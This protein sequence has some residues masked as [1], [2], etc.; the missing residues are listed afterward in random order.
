MRAC[1]IGCSGAGKTTFGKRLAARLACPFVELDAIYHQAYW[2]P[3]DDDAF[4]APADYEARTTDAGYAHVRFH[5]LRSRRATAAFL[6]RARAVA[7]K[8]AKAEKALC[9]LAIGSIHL[10]NFPGRRSWKMRGSGPPQFLQ[11]EK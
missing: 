1:V 10:R 6:R 7:A 2:T 4:R 9:I 3:L 8:G 5:R 11:G